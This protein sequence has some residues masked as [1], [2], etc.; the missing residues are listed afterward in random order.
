MITLTDFRWSFRGDLVFGPGVLHDPHVIADLYHVTASELSTVLA[1]SRD[2]LQNCTRLSCHR[3]PL[4][5]NGKTKLWY[6]FTPFLVNLERQY[7]SRST[8]LILHG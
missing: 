3:V 4:G 6:R 1:L 7:T 2:T 5:G 8:Q